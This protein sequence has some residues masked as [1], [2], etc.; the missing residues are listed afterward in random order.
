MTLIVNLISDQYVIL[1]SDRRVTWFDAK[2]RPER[3]DDRENKAIV[4]GGQFLMGY[5][6]FAELGGMR[7]EQ[8]VCQTLV[9]VDPSQQFQTL[10][11]RSQAAVVRIKRTHHLPMERCGHA[12]VAAGYGK[13]RSAPNDFIACG[14]T[15]SNAMSE[16]GVT[17]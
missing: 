10:A 1:A 17:W 7:T 9:G 3:H 13:L 12:F 5:T 8:W 6:G 11:D 4:L 15:I 2:G 16:P 14:V